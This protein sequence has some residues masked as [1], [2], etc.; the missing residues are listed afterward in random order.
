M[1][2]GH[3]GSFAQQRTENVRSDIAYNLCVA[4]KARKA[5]NRLSPTI[6]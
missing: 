1:L 4:P 5:A 3:E 6:A 2:G